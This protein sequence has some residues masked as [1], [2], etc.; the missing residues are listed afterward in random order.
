MNAQD[1][2]EEFKNA[3][4]YL[5]CGFSGMD[6]ASIDLD[7]NKIRISCDDKDCSIVVKKEVTKNG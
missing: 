5:G 6:E 1:F 4:N 3:L 2:Y 7:G